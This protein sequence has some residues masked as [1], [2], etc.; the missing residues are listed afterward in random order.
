VTM[1]NTV[2]R[3]VTM[4][5]WYEFTDI[6]EEPIAPILYPKRKKVV[7]SAV[8]LNLYQTTKHSNP[9]ASTLQ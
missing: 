7:F 3:D 4:F 9:G 5:S 1:K 2:L 6:S 8:S